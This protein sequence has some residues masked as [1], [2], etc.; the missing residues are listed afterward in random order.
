MRDKSVQEITEV[1]FPLARKV[2]L[3]APS[4]P[5]AVRPE[6]LLQS[7]DHENME[8]AADVSSAVQRAL[9]APLEST[10]FITGSLY[11]VGEA[12]PLLVK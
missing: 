11:L 5:R 1:L 3:T 7:S 12:R 10:V 2:I 8:I 6:A 9:S 4:Q